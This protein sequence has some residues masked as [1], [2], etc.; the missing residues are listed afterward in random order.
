MPPHYV[1][2][3]GLG[4]DYLVMVEQQSPVALNEGRVQLICHRNFG[5][6]SDGILL[7]VPSDKADFGTIEA[8]NGAEG[9]AIFRVRLPTRI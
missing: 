6:G 2:S 8:E 1:K 3:H 5:V 7:L 4:N 9:G